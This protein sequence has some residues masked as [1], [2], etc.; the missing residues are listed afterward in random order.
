MVEGDVDYLS[1]DNIK[2]IVVKLGYLERRVKKI[3]LAS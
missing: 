2:D 3:I 1:V